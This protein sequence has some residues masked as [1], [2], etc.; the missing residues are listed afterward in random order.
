MVVLRNMDLPETCSK[1]GLKTICSY[2]LGN[3]FINNGRDRR[4]ELVQVRK[5]DECFFP[6]RR[7]FQLQIEVD[8]DDDILT[9]FNDIKDEIGSCYHHIDTDTILM[10]EI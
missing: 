1:C 10:K 2:G 6:K 7:T 5:E 4:C 8:S 9:I 3:G